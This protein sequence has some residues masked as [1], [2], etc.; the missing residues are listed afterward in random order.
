[1]EVYM[2]TLFTYLIYVIISVLITAFVAQSLFKNGLT[3]L[4][5]A[6]GGNEALAKS[7]NHLLVVGFYLINIGYVLYVLKLQTKP[8]DI[9]SSIE[10]LSGKL[11]TVFI[12][13]GFIHF[14]NIFALYRFRNNSVTKR[15]I[16][17]IE[18]DGF[19]ASPIAD[20]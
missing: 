8:V 5:D 13:L 18:P 20:R 11:G 16:G 15:A 17:A 1:M 10:I 3:F 12:L 9:E 19:I 2:I 14:F 4:V 7:V 6:F